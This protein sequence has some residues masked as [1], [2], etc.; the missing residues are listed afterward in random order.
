M[1]SAITKPS[2]PTQEQP[3]RFFLS[4]MAKAEERVLAAKMLIEGPQPM[5]LTLD[6]YIGK[7]IVEAR[8]GVNLLRKALQDE[9]PAAAHKAARQAIGELEAAVK[10]ATTPSHDRLPASPHEYSARYTAALK[11]IAD[12]E[13]HSS[14]AFAL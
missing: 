11:Y 2:F 13:G 12:A 8:S 10:L 4:N 3:Y 9:A 1:P 14:M 7:S 6:A 5:D